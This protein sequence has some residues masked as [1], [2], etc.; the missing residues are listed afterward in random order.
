M[1]L[2]YQRR[3]HMTVP[4]RPIPQSD[5]TTDKLA[6]Q[7]LGETPPFAPNGTPPLDEGPDPFDPERLRLPQ[8]FGA[9]LGVKKALLTLPVRKPAKEWFIRVRPETAYHLQTFVI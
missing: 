3:D 2:S 4:R 7:L 1:H 5:P 6:P 9:A 8:D